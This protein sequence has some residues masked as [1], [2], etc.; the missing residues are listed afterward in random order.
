[1]SGR[2]SQKIFKFRN[3]RHVVKERVSNH[4][5]EPAREVAS[6]PCLR[7]FKSR[8]TVFLDETFWLPFP[9]VTK[10]YLMTCDR[11]EVGLDH[12]MIPE[13]Y[14]DS[15]N[16]SS[17]HRPLLYSWQNG[18]KQESSSPR[19]GGFTVPQEH[20]LSSSLLCNL[21]LCGL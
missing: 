17:N 4:C 13:L 18:A 2:S 1:M 20:P 5:N 11:W 21:S 7:V 14:R 9:R 15:V 19:C 8:K 10:C 12:Q 3:W 6:P 16:H